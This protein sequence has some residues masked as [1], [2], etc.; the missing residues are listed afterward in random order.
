VYRKLAIALAI[1]AV[2][3]FAITY[4]NLDS[5][6]HFH[7]NINRA[8][9]ALLM[10]ALMA[11]VMLL[12]MRSMFE[13]TRLNVLLHGV[14]LGVAVLVFLLIR[15]QAPVGDEQFIRSMVPHHSSAVLM[16]EESAITDPELSALCDEI[17]E[18]QLEEIAQMEDILERLS[19]Q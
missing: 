8:Y 16:C 6:N 4:V 7:A 14:F 2:I 3:M 18:T 15:F 10:V 1:N 11:V 19:R 5:L 17:V 13:S 9:M 12:V